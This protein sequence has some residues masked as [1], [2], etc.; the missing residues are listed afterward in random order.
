MIHMKMN[1]GSV[2]NMTLN[3][4]RLYL[5]KDKNKKAYN[6]YIQSTNKQNINEMEIA[7]IL[8]T[9]YLCANLEEYDSCMSLEDFLEKLP[10]DRDVIMEIWLRLYSK[11][12]LDS[13][14]RLEKEQRKQE[15]K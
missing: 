8:Y 13:L 2:L 3:F 11:K 6:E 15:V 7:K 5:L 10:E 12:K 9:A 4:K 14:R 1:D